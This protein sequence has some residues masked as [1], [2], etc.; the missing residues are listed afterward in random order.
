MAPLLVIAAAV[1]GCEILAHADRDP[2]PTG[3]GGTG[4]ATASTSSG[5]SGSSGGAGGATV[6]T[7]GSGGGVE[8]YFPFDCP[9]TETDCTRKTCVD[10]HCGAGPVAADTPTSNQIAGDCKREVC[11]GSGG[12]K[13]IDDDTDVLVDE[14]PCTVDKCVAGAPQNPPASASEPCAIDGGT[15]CDGTGKCVACVTALQCAGGACVN[16]TCVAIECVNATKDGAETDIDCGGPSC[17]RCAAGKK[18]LVSTDC[19]SSVCTGSVCQPPDC[20]DGLQNGTETDVDCGGECTSGCASGKKCAL[21]IDCA[22]GI[23]AGGTCQA[24]CADGEKNQDETGIDC[25]GG[26]PA[27]A[28]GGGCAGPGDC[29]SGVCAGGKCIT[30]I[31]ECADTLLDVQETDVDCGG[32]SCAGCQAGQ[33][34]ASGADCASRRCSGGVCQPLVLLSEVRTRGP[35][36]SHDEL[37]ELYNPLGTPVTLDTGWTL[38]TRSAI[39]ACSS[40]GVKVIF[41]GAG[42]VIAPHGH[43]LLGGS[44]YTQQPA[45]DAALGSAGL[46]DAGSLVLLQ[47]TEVV[48]A[49]CYAYDATTKASLTG[50]SAP[51]VCE[52][53]P[54]SNLPHDNT[55]SAASNVDASL[56]RKP[57]AGLGNWRDTNLSSADFR[58]LTPAKPES[59]ASPPAP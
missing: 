4:G 3:S 5:A 57:G 10:H 6:S 14:N 51:Y 18:C 43:L 47:G 11:D 23:C 1:A 29:K 42:Q 2:S 45:A 12:T 55:Q 37:V 35:G 48:D 39:G 17:A 44:A 8:C 21:D 22:G 20:G 59:A 32:P 52:G 38:A 33:L 31:S 9:G 34:C 13:L 46:P 56:E 36:G 41:T 19:A 15:V 54:A 40:N 16:N 58:N 50:C 24:T 49:L 28:D 30:P 7:S 27:C 25:G 26:C 53:E